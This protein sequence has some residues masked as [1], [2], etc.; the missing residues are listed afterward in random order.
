MEQQEI[1]AQIAFYKQRRAL[2]Q[3]GRFR[4]LENGWQVSLDGIF[5]AGVF[6]TLAGAA[7]GY[8]RLR[9]VGPNKSGRYAVRTR[10]QALRIGQF[11]ALV[12]HVAPVPLDPNG[13]VLRTADRHFTLPD[14]QE[15]YHVSGAALVS[16]ILLAPM[17]RGTGYDKA[18]RTQA[19]F[20]SNLYIIEEEPE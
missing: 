11:G 15:E 13:V 6:H 16:G 18:Q 19:D 2:F 9:L 12:K 5:A 8:E 17:F 3:F 7:P 20:G 1:A 14:A 10:V 4:R